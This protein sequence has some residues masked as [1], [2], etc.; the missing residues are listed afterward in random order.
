MTP[1]SK[2]IGT[3]RVVLVI[4]IAVASFSIIAYAYFQTASKSTTLVACT[5]HYYSVMGQEHLYVTSNRTYTN[6]T[7]T[8]LSS[9]N[10]FTSTPSISETGGSFAV[11]TIPKPPSA[12]IILSC[13]LQSQPSG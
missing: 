8:T 9:V 1:K 12:W 3:Q 7:T 10:T 11:T 5:E 6:L 2:G 4:V 13:T